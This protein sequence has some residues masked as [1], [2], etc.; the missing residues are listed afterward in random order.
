MIEAATGKGNKGMTI[1][2]I[3]R[4]AGVA[5]STVSLVL[6]S[7]PGVRKEMREKITRM[8]LENGYTIRQSAPAAAAAGE[9]RFIRYLSATHCP[10]RNEDFFAGVLGGTEQ[11]ASRLGHQLSLSSA[12]PDQ[13]GALLASLETQPG[14][15]G[16]LFLGS[17]L[18]EEQIPLLLDCK[19]PLVAV[20]LPA[21]LE[22]HPLDSIN[23]DN[24]GGIF[25]AMQY[26]HARGHREIGFLRAETELGG[27]NN[28]YMSF[29]NAMQTH[30]LEIN[31]G[32]MLRLDPQYDVA[33]RQ[34]QDF[35]QTG[36]QLPTAWIAANDII[37][38]GA[39]RALQQAGYRVPE[40]ISIIGFDD[41]AICTFTVPPLTTMRINRARLGE[42][43]VDRLL[44]L[45]QSPDDVVVKSTISVQ[46]IERDSVLPLP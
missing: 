7:K 16:V 26:L 42:L 14:L 18:T 44:A 9:I 36:P 29:C 43:A 35:L 23:T 21:H 15:L 11:Y 6:N 25:R 28:R 30:G 22:H 27:L 32:Y 37:A 19:L 41:G 12:T 33:T 17:E 10:E 2:E 4:Q 20:D 8:L 34:M 46:L 31:P 45:C 13:L 5:A 39:I 1:R 40:D 3:A 24:V 38:A